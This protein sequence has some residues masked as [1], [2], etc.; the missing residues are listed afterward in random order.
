[1]SLPKKG[2]RIIS[3]NELK[4]RWISTGN[5]YGIDVLV[6]RA[7]GQ[8]QLFCFTFRYEYDGNNI[9]LGVTPGIVEK[10]VN[11]AL[12]IGWEPDSTG[13][14]HLHRQEVEQYI[15]K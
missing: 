9:Q 5:E 4:Y 3:V 13:T 2:T 15:K 10:F 8:G 14:F 11:I 1:M 12:N 6:E 7:Q